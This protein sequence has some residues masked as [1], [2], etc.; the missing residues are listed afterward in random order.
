MELFPLENLKNSKGQALIESLALSAAM[1]AAITVLFGVLYFGFV[2]VG[3]NYLLHELLICE[4]TQGEANCEKTFRQKTQSFLFAA[5]IQ[6]LDKRRGRLV[7]EMPMKRKLTIQ[8]N[9][10]I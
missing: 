7:L 10:R 1:I 8:K 3:A 6:F 2:H 5:K 9:L 4:A